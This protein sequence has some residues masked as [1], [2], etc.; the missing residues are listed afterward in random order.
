MGRWKRQ[1][2]RTG[3]PTIWLCPAG[4]P[5]R[6]IL[7]LAMLCLCLAPTSLQA[8]SSLSRPLVIPMPKHLRLSGSAFR[9]GPHTRLVVADDA[10]VADK[11]AALS[12]RQALHEQFG[13]PPLPIVREQRVHGGGRDLLLFGETRRVARLAA[14]LTQRGACVP[15]HSAGYCLRVGVGQVLVAGGTC[16]GRFTGRRRCASCSSGTSTACMSSRPR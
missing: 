4:L 16:A 14:A 6:C 15:P 13:L 8:A 2:K 5:K 7:A 3:L 9:V 10:T 11:A 1:V 12:V